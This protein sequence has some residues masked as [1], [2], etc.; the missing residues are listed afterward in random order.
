[1]RV[2]HAD[3]RPDGFVE[4]LRALER[5]LGQAFPAI[6]LHPAR[7]AE[8]L[9]ARLPAAPSLAEALAAVRAADVFLAWGCVD[10]Q[11]GAFAAFEAQVMPAVERAL[12]GIDRAPDF[13]SDAANA[14][15]AKLLVS[16]PGKPVL[17][18]RYL[19]HGPLASFAMVVAMREAVDRKRRPHLE[20][21]LSHVADALAAPGSSADSAVARREVAPH[22]RQALTDALAALTPRQRTLLK[23]QLI[24][25]FS[26]DRLAKLYG[27]HRATTTRWLTEARGAVFDHVT[28]ALRRQLKAGPQ[29]LA[30]LHE[31]LAMAVDVTLSGVLENA[32]PEPNG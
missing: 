8:F 30:R 12:R 1:M 19:G 24:K 14:V 6:V 11:P 5:D 27:V 20:D 18:S 31:D 17:L 4:A 16:A 3:A 28:E 21:T 29:T 32:E 13:V 25:G 2:S 10:R 15:R 9:C 7:F 23:L 22:L 26:A